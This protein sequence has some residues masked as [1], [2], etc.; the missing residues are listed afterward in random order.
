MR[1]VAA[2]DI[3]PLLLHV[4]RVISQ[5]CFYVISVG[6]QD[7]RC[8]DNERSRPKQTEDGEKSQYFSVNRYYQRTVALSWKHLFC[9]YINDDDPSMDRLLVTFNCN[10]KS[11][12][13]CDLFKRDKQTNLTLRAVQIA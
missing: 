1:A 12:T 6:D 4:M 7:K 3:V 2:S 10:P 9:T 11:G 13:K 8:F 5:K